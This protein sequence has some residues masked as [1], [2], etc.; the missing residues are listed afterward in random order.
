[1][2]ITVTVIVVQSVGS[3]IALLV[4]NIIGH[5][6]IVIKPLG[7]PLKQVRNIAGGTI[8]GDGLVALILDVPSIVRN[9]ANTKLYRNEVETTP[10]GNLSENQTKHILLAEDTLTTAM[11]EKD[12]LESAGFNV[13]HALDG[14]LAL[15]MAGNEH[16]DLIITDVLM[17]KMNGF[18]LT[19]RIKQDSRLS[20][21]P[22]IIVTTREGD[23]DIRKGMEA[24]AD[25]YILKKDFTSDTLLETIDRLIH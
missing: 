1:M 13:T 19:Q 10:S 7:Y 18:E 14:Q 4:D 11:L 17:P 21:I 3:K 24:G 23:E 16:F 9:I 20:E 8:L 22:V 2:K 6:E 12:V 5:Q 15:D 25:A